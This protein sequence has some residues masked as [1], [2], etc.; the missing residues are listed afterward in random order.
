MDWKRRAE[1]FNPRKRSAM[2]NG[3][4]KNKKH[5]KRKRLS[6]SVQHSWQKCMDGFD[7]SIIEKEKEVTPKASKIKKKSSTGKK[8]NK[9]S[10]SVI[11]LSHTTDNDTAEIQCWSSTDD[12]DNSGTVSTDRLRKESSMDIDI[13][14]CE[15]LSE[16]EKSEEP[17]MTSQSEK[18][19]LSELISLAS[20]SSTAASSSTPQ[21]SHV[22]GSQKK[23]SDWL[24]AVKLKTPDKK[25]D[26]DA[27]T[28][29]FESTRK[30]KKYIRGGLAEQLQKI[31]S[32]EKSSMTFW[33]HQNSSAKKGEKGDDTSSA[34]TVRVLQISTEYGLH[35]TQCEVLS[36]TASQQSGMSFVTVLFTHSLSQQLTLNVGLIIK[37]YPP[38]QKLVITH[39][40][41]PVILCTYYCQAINTLEDSDMTSQQILSL[42][43]DVEHT[44]LSIISPKKKLKPS[45]LF[46]RISSS[47][48]VI[49]TTIIP[50]SSKKVISDSFI[51]SIEE[52]SE[53]NDS[54]LCVRATVQR[55]YC[56]QIPQ[57]NAGLSRQVRHPSH[58]YQWVLLL[59]DK[60]NA[61]CEL[62][63]PC[64]CT[65]NPTWMDC[66]KYGQ[67][68]VFTFSGIRV[69]Q[70]TNR[71]K[72]PGLFSLIDSLW[73]SEHRQLVT[74]QSSLSQDSSHHVVPSFCYIITTTGCDN[75]IESRDEV[76]LL[77]KSPKIYTLKEIQM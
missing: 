6:T 28:M 71:T 59:Q 39:R 27:M 40:R 47:P 38:W 73:S 13:S 51:D 55:I 16:D 43:T 9:R 68:K 56:K 37:I 5:A 60:H 35:V 8:N 36:D 50:L 61:F 76:S 41:E 52:C 67:G 49:E 4:I 74:D 7:D 12:D 22:T 33:S 25:S 1:G 57:S 30:K 58:R 31:V 32:R 15:S 20:S 29:Q 14:D 24:K 11:T 54:G 77:Y 65:E 53:H 19:N 46:G 34:L 42:N 3:S 2:T 48:D 23:G 10:G 44:S 75:T 63:L 72:S 21:S 66:I 64:H 70:R 69:V 26:T 18:D 45:R 62:L 17:K